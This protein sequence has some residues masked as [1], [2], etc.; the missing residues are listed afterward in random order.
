MTNRK[1]FTFFAIVGILAFNLIFG[2]TVYSEEQQKNSSDQI[3]SVR[4]LVDAVKILRKNYVDKDKVTYQKLVYA[5]LQGMVK[6]LDQ[7]SRFHK[8]AK[9]VDIKEDSAGKFAGIGVT[10]SFLDEK[11]IIKK[12][13]PNGPASK[14]AI[15]AEDIIVAIDNI[16][17]TGDGFDEAKKYLKGEVGTNVLVTVVRENVEHELSYT[18]TRDFVIVPSITRARLLPNTKLAYVHVVQFSQNTA[19]DFK[20]ELE[21]LK[22][23]GAKGLII[24]LRGNPGG[25]LSTAVKMCSF[26][27]NEDDLVI[28]TKGRIKKDQRNYNAVGGKKFLKMPIVILIDKGSA[29]ASE[30][31]A[32]CLQ[33]YHKTVLVGVKTYGKGSVQ[34]IVDLRDGSAIRF[35]IAK[36]YTKSG[37]TIHKVGIEPDVLVKISTEQQPELFSHLG[38]LFPTADEVGAYDQQDTQLKAAMG[39]LQDLIEIDQSKPIHQVFEE[40]KDDLLKKYSISELEIEKSENDEP[41]QKD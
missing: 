6:E 19:R 2:Y 41:K 5:A 16:R 3:E 17:M 10:I 26:F 38:D 37:R 27:L 4:V 33:D 24:D 21:K 32:A 18:L 31:M 28:Y 11:L 1:Q 23:A 29:S 9:N 12:I 8:P 20:S 30:I 22:A 34:T 39:V 35:T 14:S 7:H 40:H 36:Y 13:I 15:Q 25:M